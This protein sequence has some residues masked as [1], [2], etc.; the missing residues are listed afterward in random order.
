MHGYADYDRA[1]DDFLMWVRHGYADGVKRRRDRVLSIILD[2]EN[3]WGSYR[4]RGTA[5]L[6]GVYERLNDDPDLVPVTFSE[7][8]D[9]NPDRGVAPHPIEKL[10][11]ARPLF[12]AS[13]IDEMGSGDGNDL[14]I[15]IGSPHEN[16]AWQLL[17]RVRAHLDEVG[18]TPE[19]HAEAFE[20]V[21]RAEGSDWFW[22]FG[23]DFV[24]P[25]GGELMFDK[26]FREHLK[27]VYRGLGEEPPAELDRPIA[28]DIVIWSVGDP[29]VSVKPG[30]ILRVMTGHSGTVEWT[31]DDWKHKLTTPLV[32][33]GD[34]MSN[35]I[36]YAAA[37]APIPAGAAAVRFRIL[38]DV[39]QDGEQ[40]VSVAS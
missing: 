14:N 28:D 24:Q 32:P 13:W 34:V 22:W 21:Y 15:W 7:Y 33:T 4:N 12:C 26:I 25:S 19:T 5:F 8:L 1:A 11:A 35:R 2:G 17:G 6:R 29:A 10:D 37:L 20:A 23:D 38:L 36:G 9:G 27:D 31:T 16:R 40:T 3:A 30:Q 39:G 18:A